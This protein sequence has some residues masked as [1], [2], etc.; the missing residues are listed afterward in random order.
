MNTECSYREINALF[1]LKLLHDDDADRAQVLF[2]AG[3]N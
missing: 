1:S 2:F 3:V